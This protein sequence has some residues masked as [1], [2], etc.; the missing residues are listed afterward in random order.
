MVGFVSKRLSVAARAAPVPPRHADA[1][2]LNDLIGLRAANAALE[3]QL[4]R[5]LD[6]CVAQMRD[7]IALKNELTAAYDAKWELQQELKRVERA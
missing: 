1:I 6:R 5:T 4:E 2:T 7:L 3:A